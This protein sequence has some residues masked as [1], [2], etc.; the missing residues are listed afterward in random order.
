MDDWNT[1]T[2]EERED[3]TIEQPLVQEEKLSGRVP[4]RVCMR[5][6]LVIANRWFQQLTCRRYSLDA[7]ESVIRLVRKRF[8]YQIMDFRSFSSSDIDSDHNIIMGNC[9]FKFKTLI[10]GYK[11]YTSNYFQLI[12]W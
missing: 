4:D 9:A 6:H 2:G 5:I 12:F 7:S 1:V 11:F 8:K 10:N 3:E